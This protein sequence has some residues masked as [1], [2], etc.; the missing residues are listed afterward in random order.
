MYRPKQFELTDRELCWQIIEQSSFCSLVSLLPRAGTS[1]TPYATHLPLLLDRD[2]GVEGRL[3]GHL[4]RAN[5]HAALLDQGEALAI[6]SGPHAYVSPR[7]Y[8]SDDQV[9]TWNYV[10]VHAYG[11]PR[12]LPDAE[13]AER[14]L[15]QLSARYEPSAG[16]S[17]DQ[18]PQ[19]RLAA[20]LRGIVAFEV[21]I[22]RLEGKLK[23]S[24]NRAPDDAE[25][26]RAALANSPDFT[27]REL[28][29][30]MARVNSP[31]QT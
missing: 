16:W 21:P 28:A 7:Y 22:A 31:N 8:L 29:A 23:L 11:T 18:L 30:W 6:F 26:A 17:P 5:P 24:Q 13:D 27:E 9:P 25:G 3:I 19:G 15:R 4:A 12:L 2:Q 14:V 1:A 10:A 20:L